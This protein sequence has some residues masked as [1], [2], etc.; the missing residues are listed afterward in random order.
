MIWIQKQDHN[1]DNHPY[2]YFSTYVSICVCYSLHD[3]ILQAIDIICPQLASLAEG[4]G[5][6]LFALMFSL[7]PKP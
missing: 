1:F 7:N 2:C 3:I 4:G 6:N 5:A